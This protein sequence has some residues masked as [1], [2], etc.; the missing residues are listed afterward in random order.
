[1]SVSRLVAGVV[2]LPE[3]SKKKISSIIGAVVADAA[4][5]PLEW[6]YQ[7]DKMKEIVGDSN[8]EFWPESKCPFFTVPTGKISC[9]TDELIST[10]ETLANSDGNLDISLLTSA[11]QT[12]FGSPDSPYQVALAKR[13]DKKYPVPGP[14]INGGVI[15][16][17]ANMQDGVVPSGSDSCED[18]DG[19]AISLPSY[20]LKFCSE[21]SGNTASILTTNQVALSH[22]DV[23]TAI[24][25]NFV[26][27]INEPVIQVKEQFKTKHPEIVT[28][29]E[30]VLN[31]TT[32]GKSVKDIVD[33]CGKACGL[34]GS[35]QGALASIVA[36]PD[37]VWAVR[38]NILAGGDC[39]ARA[40][41]MGACLGAKFGIEGIP[42]EWIE[43]VD[44][45]N[46]ILENAVKIFA[47][48]S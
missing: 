21:Q 5:L 39:N 12:K 1:M 41:F 19:Y 25:K 38:K 8:P 36:A 30:Y 47:A 15:K 24:I 29:I 45:I 17:L 44:G 6:I 16:S 18:N 3:E 28:E 22:L 11:I 37:Y 31:L 7:D 42:M 4:S 23:Q 48:S 34:P 26:T 27:G 33:T 32:E 20:L 9:Y 2:G 10:L 13:A 14:W 40:N 46:N 43:K 35:F